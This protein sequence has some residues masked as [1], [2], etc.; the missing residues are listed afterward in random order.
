M[1][2]LLMYVSLIR[3]MKHLTVKFPEWLVMFV[4]IIPRTLNKLIS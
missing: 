2:R 4:S 1:T 3:G